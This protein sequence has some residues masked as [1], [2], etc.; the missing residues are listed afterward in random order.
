[1]VLGAGLY[2]EERLYPTEQIKKPVKLLTGAYI[3]H[4]Y[5]PEDSR[6]NPLPKVTSLFVA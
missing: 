1:M 2:T 4:L 3:Y 5:S 6:H